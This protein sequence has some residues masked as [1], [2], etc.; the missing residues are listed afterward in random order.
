MTRIFVFTFAFL[1][2]Y[3]GYTQHT[4]KLLNLYYQ[5]DYTAVTNILVD[6]E[7]LETEAL[8]IIANAFH[9]LKDF[10]SALMYY[11]LAE[12]KAYELEDYFLN[13]AICEISSG[14]FESA[15]RSLFNFE[16]QV[17]DHQMIHYY[18]GVIDFYSMEYKTGHQSLD[19]AL[20]INPEYTDAWYLKAAI[21]MEEEKYLKAE[22]CFQEVLELDPMN[23]SAELYLAVCKIYL[24]DFDEA[25]QDLNKIIDSSEINKAEALYY[26]G[27]ANFHLHH[28]DQAC[29][30]WKDSAFLGDAFAKENVKSICEKGKLNRMKSRKVTKI[31]L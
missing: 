30:D 22:E 26:R 15:E 14:D 20:E 31:A 19:M 23:E 2:T 9:K 18:F 4:E 24:K 28:L 27:E 6:D 3:A 8:F 12:E 21:F 5:G 7:L 13:R 16:D 17:G 11:D 25:F 1:C 10:E 29:Q